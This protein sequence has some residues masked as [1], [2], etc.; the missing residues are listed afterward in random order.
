MW[1]GSSSVH[2]SARMHEV[3]RC[4]ER[5]SV[6]RWENPG[7]VTKFPANPAG[8]SRLSRVCGA[9]ANQLLEGGLVQVAE[10]LESH[11]ALADFR[12]GQRFLVALRKGPVAARADIERNVVLV[13]GDADAE[14]VAF[15]SALV[16]V[17]VRTVCQ[18]AAEDEGLQFRGHF[19]DQGV[20][21]GNFC[22]A[23]LFELRQ[24]LRRGGS[25]ELAFHDFIGYHARPPLRNPPTAPP[26]VSWGRRFR[27]SPR[28]AP[29]TRRGSRRC[30]EKSFRGPAG[31]WDRA[32]SHLKV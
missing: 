15:A 4:Y 8:N 17:V 30:Q 21:G 13:A 22:L 19:T 6:S 7:T 2:P 23:G 5:A 24:V 25:S 29:G 28:S 11:A 31:A 1:R 20:E 32:R 26:A 10:A 9:F 18:H 12:L 3:E 27:R 14:P 16:L